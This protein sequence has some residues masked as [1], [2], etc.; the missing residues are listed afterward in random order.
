MKKYLLILMTV[1]L[2]GFSFAGCSAE[3]VDKQDVSKTQEDKEKKS[4]EDD[5]TLLESEG[6]VV[7]T[8]PEGQEAA[9][10]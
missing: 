7:I 9:G 1:I 6:D 2:M 4:D 3:K 8:V 5:A 10:E